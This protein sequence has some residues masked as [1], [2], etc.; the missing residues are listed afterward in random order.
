MLGRSKVGVQEQTLGGRGKGREEEFRG[1]KGVGERKDPTP[2]G[3]RTTLW[4]PSGSP[5][6]ALPMTAVPRNIG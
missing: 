6:T 3:L 5:R 4:E 1:S 2:G